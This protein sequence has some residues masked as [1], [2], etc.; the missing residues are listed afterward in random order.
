[1]MLD[2][3]VMISSDRMYR[4]IYS[5]MSMVALMLNRCTQQVISAVGEKGRVICFELFV[6]QDLHR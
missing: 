4:A 3:N 2:F 5:A 6:E 1:M